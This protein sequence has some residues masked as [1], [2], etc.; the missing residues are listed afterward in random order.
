MK[1]HPRLRRFLFPPAW[2]VCLLCAAS[3]AALVYSF[4]ALSSSDMRS[5]AAYALSFYALCLLCLRVPGLVRFLARFRRENPYYLRYRSS[6]RL[7]VGISLQV[8]LLFHAAYASF[9]LGLGLWHK[10][11]WFYSMS[12]YHLL[13][14]LMQLSLVFFLK[15]HAPGEDIP[16]Q[17][18]RYRLCGACLL[19]MNLLLAVFILYFVFRIRIFRHHQI[20][21]IAMAACTF[22]SLTLAIT[23][24]V[25][26]RRL[27]SPICAAA[28]AISLA[29]SI[30]SMLMLEN[31]LL[32]AFGQENSL[33]FHQVMLGSGGAAVILLVQGIALYMLVKSRRMLRG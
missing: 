3:A 8:S 11:V 19:M 24:A 20:T 28:K 10:S 9:Q 2:L 7:R 22:T 18:R 27:S 29:S 21:T 5:I 17:W 30:V 1:L 12:G 31:A 25:R 16:S 26:S 33:L 6:L 15:D 32:T 23:G 4:C 14:A 13:L